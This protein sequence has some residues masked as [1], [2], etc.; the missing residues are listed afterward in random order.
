MKIK[1]GRTNNPLLTGLAGCGKIDG[2]IET[3]IY[4]VFEREK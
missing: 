4:S 3:L 1:T 2:D